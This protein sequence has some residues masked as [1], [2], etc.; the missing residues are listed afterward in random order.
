MDESGKSK[1]SDSGDRFLLS[2]VIIEKDLNSALSN[3]MVSLKS[4]NNIPTDVN[5]HAYDLF[6]KEE[7]KDVKLKINEIDY[8]FNHFIHLVR[9]T[10]M[11]CILYEASKKDFSERIKKKAKQKKVSEKSVI[12]YLQTKGDHDIL[13]EILTA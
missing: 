9:G 12:K 5:I 1:L 13:Y 8:F 11:R 4:K 10:E 2:A 3:F 6:E 7:V